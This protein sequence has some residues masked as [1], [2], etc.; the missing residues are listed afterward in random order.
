MWDPQR[1]TTLWASMACYRDS[2]TLPFTTSR[3]RVIVTTEYPIIP[4]QICCISF[5]LITEAQR[6]SYK[7]RYIDNRSLN[8][9]L[10]ASESNEGVWWAIRHVETLIKCFTI[11]C[12]ER[13]VNVKWIWHWGFTKEQLTIKKIHCLE[14]VMLNNITHIQDIS[15]LRIMKFTDHV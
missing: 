5:T 12:K 14:T 3:Y 6:N 2:F 13:L 1:L 4:R 8:E 11:V 10:R 9:V 7:Y 15:I